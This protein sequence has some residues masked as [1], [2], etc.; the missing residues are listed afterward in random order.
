MLRPAPGPSSRAAVA[1][2]MRPSVLTSLS[3][4][5]FRLVAAAAEAE[6]AASSSSSS[7]PLSGRGSLL[8][9][10]PPARP[11]ADRSLP[12]WQLAG[13]TPGQAHHPRRGGRPPPLGAAA[14]AAPPS[15]PSHQEKQAGNALLGASPTSPR[16]PGGLTLPGPGVGTDHLLGSADEEPDAA[17][18]G[19]G[20]PEGSGSADALPRPHDAADPLPPSP[21]SAASSDHARKLSLFRS[22]YGAPAKGAPGRDESARAARDA[23]ALFYATFGPPPGAG[24]P[25]RGRWYRG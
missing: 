2:P 5:V 17:E 9:S 4:R 8:S 10:L 25:R 13:S 14:T 23:L 12:P 1:A 11:T 20:G 6:S 16:P 15:C 22:V 21:S 3:Q 18:A 24:R 7:R 19:I